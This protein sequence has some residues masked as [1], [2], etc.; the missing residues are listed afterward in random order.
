M[1][2]ILLPKS[3]QALQFGGEFF[4]II[5]IYSIRVVHVMDLAQEIEGLKLNLK[6]HWCIHQSMHSLQMDLVQGLWVDKFHLR[7][8]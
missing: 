1:K 6:N 4:G 2:K 7:C 8:C 3:T 5:G